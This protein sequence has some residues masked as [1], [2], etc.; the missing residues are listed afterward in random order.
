MRAALLLTSLLA[1]LA[2][3]PL[4]GAGARSVPEPAD[5]ILWHGKL[6][7]VDE[8]FSLAQAMAVRQ[9]RIVRVGSDADVLALRGA[10][11][12]VVD[13]G[14]RTVMPGLIDSHTHPTMASMHEFG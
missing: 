10:S 13:L 5:L 3:L 4:A 9:G 12:R 2:H 7:T 6:V 1:A 11:T 14:G 8:R